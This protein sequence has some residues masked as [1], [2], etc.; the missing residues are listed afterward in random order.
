MKQL[1]PK[2][3][4]VGSVSDLLNCVSK[5]IEQFS[6]AM[7]LICFGSAPPKRPFSWYLPMSEPSAPFVVISGARLRCGSSQRLSEVI[8]VHA[9]TRVLG[10][11]PM[12][13][14]GSE[15]KNG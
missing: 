1:A 4:R 6:T 5:R 9:L 15:S 2:L 3:E 8:Q 11:L 13:E 10:L 7:L 14:A 12:N